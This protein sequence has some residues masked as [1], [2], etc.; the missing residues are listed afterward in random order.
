[1]PVIP[2][3]VHAGDFRF[4]PTQRAAAR[5][6]LGLAGDDLMVLFVGRLSFHAKAHPLAMYQA[7]ERVALRM[8]RQRIVLVECG[9]FA[10][11]PIRLAY[12]SAA[13]AACP[14]VRRLVLDGRQPEAR[15]KAWAGADVFCSLSDNIQETFGIVPI[16]AMAAGLPVVASDWDGYRDT[17]RDGVDGFLIPTCMAPP[18]TGQ[19]LAARHAAGIDS[20]DRYCGY[21]SS[22]VAI[23]IEATAHALERLLQS[24][25]HRRTMGEAGRAHVAER[26]DW[27]PIIGHYEALWDELT[28][29]RQ[30]AGTVPPR[31]WPARLDPFT[32]FQ[33]YPSRPL[34]TDLRIHVAAPDALERLGRWQRLMM[35]NYAQAIQPAEAEIRAWLDRWSDGESTCGDWVASLPRGEQARAARAL[36]WLAKLGIVR[37]T[38][39]KATPGPDA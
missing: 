8:P 17:V 31:P 34:R 23:D 33:H 27:K 22:H 7:L 30:A 9:W 3:G 4:T 25:E 15:Q 29:R 2:L 12:E 19:D 32:A 39:P 20:Y 38:P 37:L 10:N 28:V 13:Q 5:Q 11:D 6:A 24:P 36:V 21:T 14:S 1:L 18:G 26:F 16:E 35:V